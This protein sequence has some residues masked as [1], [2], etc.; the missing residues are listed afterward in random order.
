MYR[1]KFIPAVVVLTALVIACSR[2]S[3]S[4]VA[5]SGAAPAETANADD[6]V[7]LKAS[8]PR[9]VSPVNDA[10]VD[11]TNPSLVIQR[12]TATFDPS[13]VFEYR[14]QV[15]NEAGGLVWDSGALYDTTTVTIP[16]SISMDFE[17]RYTWRARAEANRNPGP[18]TTALAT[19]A[20]ASFITPAG[21]YLRG[22]ELRDPLQGGK[23][24]GRTSGAVTFNAFGARLENQSSY[25]EWVLPQNLT[26]GE[27]SA[28]MTNIGNGSEE[29]KT[30][31]MS[32][33]QGDGV[34]ITDNEFR[35]TADKR[36][37]WA[38]QGSRI[39]YTVR[40]GGDSIEPAGG[41]QSW[42]RSQ[43]YFWKY[44][45]GNGRA[46]LR[47][48]EGGKNGRLMEDLS[49]NYKGTYRPNPHVIRLGSVGGRGG[50]DTNPG[51]TYRNVWVSANP[52]PIFSPEAQ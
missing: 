35:F 36:T 13:A 48:Y 52:R 28:E 30:K 26:A 11:V 16:G 33:M 41:P 45:W 18:W 1:N 12:A 27:F 10:K 34:N 24:L 42:S 43:I 2:P 17:K 21:A 8:A 31:V 47:V 29:W 50:D 40:S 9:V 3:P 32:M 39:R 4:P 6:P 22:S 15:L 49:G 46:R 44:E 14:F 25:I 5:P 51:T 37:G 20:A 23:T 19:N 7:T 38:G